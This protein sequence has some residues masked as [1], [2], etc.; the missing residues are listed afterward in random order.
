[1]FGRGVGVLAL[2]VPSVCTQGYYASF[3]SFMFVCVALF[4]FV[5]RPHESRPRVSASALATHCSAHAARHRG[6]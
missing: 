2:Q 1:M 5:E 4:L 3:L 6:L